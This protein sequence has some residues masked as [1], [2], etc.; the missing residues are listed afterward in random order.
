MIL[1]H[2]SN[3]DIDKIDLKRSKKYKDFG[4]GF[5]LTTIL[6]Q[7][8]E[9]AKAKV[10]IE[11]GK[12]TVIFF[13]VD[14]N[15]LKKLNYKNFDKVNVDWAKFIVNNR[16][17]NFK[18]Y[19]NPLSNHDNKYDVVSG[20]IADDNVLGS[21]E[22]YLNN[23]IDEKYL[24]K[25]LKY[26]KLNDQYSFHTPKAI[27]LLKKVESIV[28]YNTIEQETILNQIVPKIIAWIAKDNKMNLDESAK[29]FYSLKISKKIENTETLLYTQSADYLYELVKEELSNK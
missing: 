29:L 27:E 19:S 16:N 11:G 17:S 3:Q 8:I 4:T 6:D 10:K 9:R 21:I 2:G 18:D 13:E 12:P 28:Y 1:F 5:Y 23:T 14:E 15:E 7:A 26:A 20:P 24:I 25:R 22:L